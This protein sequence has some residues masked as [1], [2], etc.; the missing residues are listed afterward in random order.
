MFV[1]AD[2]KSPVAG[3]VTVEDPT[4]AEPAIES[5]VKSGLIVHT[6]SDANAKE[7]KANNLSRSLTALGSG[8][9]IISTDF[10]K[11]DL[12]ISSYQVHLPKGLV[13][14]CNVILGLDRCANREVELD[15]QTPQPR[16][17]H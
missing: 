15:S 14:R 11:P 7:A 10:I 2:P 6:Y 8:A 9:Q 13:A 4:K 5:Y 3:F 1:S 16:P 17:N 12:R